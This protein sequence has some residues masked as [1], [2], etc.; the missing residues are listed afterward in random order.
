[1]SQFFIAESTPGDNSKPKQ[2]SAP[3]TNSGTESRS[4]N[5]SDNKT[6]TDNTTANSQST[7]NSENKPKEEQKK[8]DSNKTV[9]PGMLVCYGAL[10]QCS[11]GTIPTQLLVTSNRK[12]YVN[13]SQGAQ[14][15]VATIKD[16]QVMNLNFG[17][18]KNGS[19]P[20]PPCAADLLWTK[21]HTAVKLKIQG[22]E[23]A[24]L[25]ENSEAT[26]KKFGGK[27]NILQNGQIPQVSAPNIDKISVAAPAANCL[28]DLQE[29]K[30][31]SKKKELR[32]VSV[33]QIKSDKVESNHKSHKSGQILIR[34]KDE[35]TFEVSQ[36]VP[37]DASGE[38]KRQ[39]DWSVFQDK[40]LKYAYGNYGAELKV[41]FNELGFYRIEASGKEKTAGKDGN[42]SNDPGA[43]IDVEV[44]NN[45]IEG[46]TF[47]VDHYHRIEGSKYFV[48]IDS[49]VTFKGQYRLDANGDDKTNTNWVLRDEGC[50]ILDHAEGVSEFT[51]TKMINKGTY[52][53]EVT[54]Y[55]K[56][57]TISL[58]GETNTVESIKG[59]VNDV[60]RHYI[61]PDEAIA[62]TVVNGAYGPDMI[63]KE[64]NA[65][66]WKHYVNSAETDET[67]PTGRSLE[68][69]TFDIGKHIVEAYVNKANAFFGGKRNKELDDWE[70]TVTHNYLTGIEGDFNPKRGK[71]VSFKAQPLMP[72]N[73][74]ETR[75]ITWELKGPDSATLKSK[76]IF[77]FKF[78][79]LGTYTLH[80]YINNSL[81]TKVIKE[82]KIKQCTIDD[83]Y[84]TD[85]DIN[86]I[87]QAGY[88][89]DVYFQVKHTGL[90]GESITLNVYD[91]DLGSSTLLYT[92]KASIPDTDTEYYKHKLTLT[93]DIRSKVELKGFT[94]DGSLYFTVIPTEVIV[95]NAGQ[96]LPKS[97]GKYLKVNKDEKIYK[98]Y[99]ADTDD[100]KRL[101]RTDYTDNAIVQVYAQNLVDK[102]VEIILMELKA[103]SKWWSV[104]SLWFLIDS[105]R[106][107]LKKDKQLKSTKVNI[108]KQGQ[109]K[110]DIGLSGLKD[111]H[112][113]DA[114][115][116]RELYA[117][118][119]YKDKIFVT[120]ETLKVTKELK[121]S[122]TS[123]A[124]EA[125]VEVDTL[126]GKKDKKVCEALVW[127]KYFSCSERSK[128][129]DICKRLG[130]DPNY[131]MA[132]M[133]LETG[134]TFDPA[135][136]NS[137]GYTGLIQIG[138]VAADD[139]N[140]RKKTNITTSD[141]RKMN[142][143]DQLT[144]VEYYLEQ[145]KGKLNTLADLYLAILMPIDVGKGSDK[146]HV[147]FDSNLELH[148]NSKGKV[149][150]DTNYTRNKGYAA[151]KGFYQ[152]DDEVDKDKKGNITKRHGKVGGK[153]YVWEIANVIQGWYL[154]G[155]GSNMNDC[156]KNCTLVGKD[157]SS[158]GDLIL[159]IYNTGKIIQNGNE[160]NAKS[161]TYIYHDG[162]SSEHNLGKW[163]L[164]EANKY[165]NGVKKK[166][167][168]GTFVTK[169]STKY[170]MDMYYELLQGK[171]KLLNIKG[172]QVKYEKGDVCIW[173]T[174]NSSREYV[175]PVP[176]ASFLGAIAATG[177]K[178]IVLNGF[179]DA[180]GIGSP[181]QTHTQGINAD[182]RLL[183]KNKT[184][185]PLMISD[186][187]LDEER[188]STFTDA[189][190]KFGFKSMISNYFGPNKDKLI[191]HCSHDS[192][193]I[194]KDHV[195]IQGFR[196]DLQ[197][198]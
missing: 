74:E 162:S 188:M 8:E 37:K 100:R 58:I 96:T 107:Y 156:S 9:K 186:P 21:E 120:P 185:S 25:S 79:K 161:V 53:A 27:V 165:A 123:K 192:A 179:T 66:K 31:L 65:I 15:L 147:V 84:W 86:I 73:N 193:G 43:S 76:N 152:E 4:N 59:T 144:Y 177:Y 197:K 136:T 154:R 81:K 28:V 82:I 22:S 75:D 11:N 106:D 17:I 93:D 151:N 104:V 141:L 126:K 196:P 1:M 150:K 148:Y 63:E 88:G 51:T 36:L 155:K 146:D 168:K 129:I 118:I 78:S 138:E 70:F 178:D 110:F 18:C 56:V 44:I 46:I 97:S 131:L 98:A 64:E 113:G 33:L 133:A 112:E 174:H 41:K 20:P 5:Q 71:T 54:S 105:V 119:K 117:I 167:S 34:S 48:R 176:F 135:I 50:S 143:L 103:V 130:C 57:M 195:H 190:F 163:D 170:K 181:S 132:A 140:R 89:Q 13:D 198:K 24:A 38:E 180:E 116:V 153:T 134:G 184:N 108:D 102:E 40:T 3:Q 29:V 16:N 114:N 169:H 87:Q 157:K 92:T 30:Q 124:G 99:L 149:I 145:H 55:G 61:R 85:E 166:P 115:K 52:W 14:K 2:T 23:V 159:H 47:P 121:S 83:G 164:I 72:L 19:N 122:D 194:H 142:K 183:N 68:A 94:N 62:F 109:A 60:E 35:L 128:I 171:I 175:A 45:S 77:S 137:L 101:I 32:A 80:A 67:M 12:Y 49:P 95:D 191:R 182:L 173:Y 158:N 189:L 160:A 127:G 42:V 6:P 90:E 39:I 139:I 7:G 10:C 187:L 125:F 111:S 91:K 69:Q 26:C 172:K